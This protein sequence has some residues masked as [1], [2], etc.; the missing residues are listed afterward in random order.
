MYPI[1]PRST[2]A[3]TVR[4]E[5]SG[6]GQMGQTEIQG[7][8]PSSPTCKALDRDGLPSFP[9]PVRALDQ[10]ARLLLDG[11]RLSGL[12]GASP[13]GP[14]A[15]FRRGFSFVL[16]PAAADPVLDLENV[17][18]GLNRF[19]LFL[20]LESF[21]FL[22]F[23]FSSCRQLLLA[24]CFGL[25]SDGPDEAQQF[26]SDCRHDL[27]LILACSHQLHV[28][29][30]WPVLLFPCNLSDLCRN[31]FL[32]SAQFSSDPWPMPIAPR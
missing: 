25:D 26:S 11:S 6:T 13:A 18:H 8:A 23:R 5:R 2:R 24:G 22:Y 20:Y 17:V 1:N 31:P 28:A 15:Y 29:A 16:A 7:A 10:N 21:C 19:L 14:V 3:V 30:V 12:V 4:A 32:S 27:P 9:A